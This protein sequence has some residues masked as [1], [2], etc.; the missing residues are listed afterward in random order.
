MT[1]DRCPVSWGSH[2]C[3]LPRGHDGEHVCTGENGC[4]MTMP[5]DGVDEGGFR[6][7]L[8]TTSPCDRWWLRGHCER[9]EYHAGPHHDGRAWYDDDGNEVDAPESDAPQP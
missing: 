7:A 6:W 4:D 3:G 9:H 1:E 8:Y 5:R 2:G